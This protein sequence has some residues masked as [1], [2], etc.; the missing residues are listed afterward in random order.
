VLLLLQTDSKPQS[1]VPHHVIEPF[2]INSEK[3]NR[4][5]MQGTLINRLHI[6]GNVRVGAQG[7]AILVKHFLGHRKKILVKVYDHIS[8]PSSPPPP[9]HIAISL[10]FQDLRQLTMKGNRPGNKEREIK[11][12]S[13]IEGV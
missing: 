5:F 7:R 2:R 4:F 9:R 10:G 8:H 11:S 1:F 3:G 6:N 13:Y 12:S